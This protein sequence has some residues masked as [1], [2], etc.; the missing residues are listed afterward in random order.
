LP[1]AAELVKKINEEQE[2]IIVETITTKTPKDFS[3]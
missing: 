2:K 1:T 3:F